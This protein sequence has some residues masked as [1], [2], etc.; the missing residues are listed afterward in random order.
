MRRAS[1]ICLS[2]ALAAFA[3]CAF[4]FFGGY[5]P[6]RLARGVYIEG[7]DFSHMP[8]YA[9]QRRLRERRGAELDGRSFRRRG[10]EKGGPVKAGGG[11]GAR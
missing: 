11:S 7:E 2:V 1:E 3:A 10:G 4:L 9:A 5:S 8:V 6:A